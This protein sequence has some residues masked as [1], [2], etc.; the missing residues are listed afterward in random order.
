MLKEMKWTEREITQA[1]IGDHEETNASM[2]LYIQLFLS[3]GSYI[4]NGLLDTII[5]DKRF[6]KYIGKSLTRF[7]YPTPKAVTTPDQGQEK[8]TLSGS[9]RPAINYVQNREIPVEP[10]GA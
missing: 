5:R 1:G 7:H 6:S 9:D 4:T 3:R 8:P 10:E 2:P